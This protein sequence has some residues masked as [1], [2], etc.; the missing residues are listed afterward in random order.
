MWKDFRAFAFKGS[1]VDLAV[2]VV[3]GAAFTGIVKAI[4][5][6]LIM[7]V[8]GAIAPDGDWQSWTVWRFQLGLVLSALLQFVIVAF[9]LY[10][11]VSKILQALRKKEVAGPPPPTETLLTEIRDLLRDGSVRATPEHGPAGSR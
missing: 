4:V 8:V 6:G 10:L 3:I 5:D 9:V 1:V 11:V 7:P 2:G